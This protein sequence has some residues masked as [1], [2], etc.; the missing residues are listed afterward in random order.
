MLNI[1]YSYEVISCHIIKTFLTTKTISVAD[2]LL[3]FRLLHHHA[4]FF[5]WN[6]S[7]K[8]VESNIGYKNN[9]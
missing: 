2:S 1:N 8:V 6:Y 4:L 3:F 5:N 9:L 7:Q